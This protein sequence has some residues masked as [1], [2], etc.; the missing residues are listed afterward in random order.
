MRAKLFQDPNANRRDG[1][2]SILAEVAAPAA[3][4]ARND[5]SSYLTPYRKAD[6]GGECD[7]QGHESP[8]ASLGARRDRLPGGQAQAV[9][10]DEFMTF[11][12][13]C[14]E[15]GLPANAT[16]PKPTQPEPDAPPSKN[17]CRLWLGRPRQNRLDATDG[18]GARP[19]LTAWPSIGPP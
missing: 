17:G 15:A 19:G 2:A 18:P 11:T 13:A 5:L 4:T 16:P 14:I 7:N 9:A 10:A 3:R 1:N 8:A 12:Q 6:L